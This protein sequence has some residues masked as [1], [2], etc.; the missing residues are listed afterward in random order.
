MLIRYGIRPDEF[1][2]LQVSGT[3]YNPWPH[4]IFYPYRAELLGVKLIKRSGLRWF[5]PTSLVFLR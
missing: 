2:D 4:S 1:I 5:S 3:I